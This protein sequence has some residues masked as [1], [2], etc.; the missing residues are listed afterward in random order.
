MIGAETTGDHWV[1]IAWR[2]VRIQAGGGCDGGD[3]DQRLRYSGLDEYR[4]TIGGRRNHLSDP[5]RPRKPDDH[6]PDRHRAVCRHPPSAYGS[7]GYQQRRGM[8]QRQSNKTAF[9]LLPLLK[10]GSAL[11]TPNSRS[12]RTS[13]RGRWDRTTFME[14]VQGC[15]V[16]ARGLHHA[17]RHRR[18]YDL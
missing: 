8:A 13:E 16:R 9:N 1:N 18:Q 5:D 12:R 6:R 2:R 14:V 10:S 7:A 11:A 17:F 15:L 3:H 4:V